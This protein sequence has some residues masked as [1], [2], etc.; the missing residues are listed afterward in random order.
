M[1]LPPPPPRTIA[2]YSDIGCPWARLCVHR[3]HR[4]RARHGLDR[5]VR[6][7][8]RPFPLELVNRRPTPKRTLDAE[9]AV[10]AGLDEEVEWRLWEAPVETFPVTTL[11]ALEAV[12][13][14]SAEQ[15]AEPAERLDLALRDALF[16]HSRCISILPVV[17]DIAASVSGVDLDILER[18]LQDGRARSRVRLAPEQV[19]GSPHLVLPGGGDAFNPGLR[20]HLIEGH[21]PVIESDDPSAIEALL[22]AAGAEALTTSAVR[23]I[24]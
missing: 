22:R 16:R 15:G 6:I 9:V 4:F 10:L 8:H 24:P 2:V 20:S 17:L 13:A 5:V 12:Q 21:I 19:T 1:S 7:E 11:L 14:V 18:A 3:L 23:D